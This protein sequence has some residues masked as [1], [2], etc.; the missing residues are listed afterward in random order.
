[1]HVLYRTVNS[2]LTEHDQLLF[3]SIASDP[4]T[5][6]ELAVRIH[7]TTIAHEAIIHLTGQ[8]KKIDVISK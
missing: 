2:M 3:Q 4:V 1:M 8:W 5:W 7:S 6:A